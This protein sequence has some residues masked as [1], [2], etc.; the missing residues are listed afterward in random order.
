MYTGLIYFT[1]VLAYT[2]LLIHFTY[3]HFVG[4]ETILT[5]HIYQTNKALT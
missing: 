5:V 1:Y 3:G 2:G 4:M